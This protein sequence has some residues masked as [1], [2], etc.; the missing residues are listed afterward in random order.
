MDTS[1]TIAVFAK[2]LRNMDRW[3][4]TAVEHAK[5]KGFDPEVYA[6]ARLAPDQYDLIR[7]VQAACDQAKYA[8]AYLSQQPP[9]SHPD[10]ERTIEELRARIQTALRYV[11]T[12]EP[13]S[14]KTPADIRISPA[15]MQ[16]KWVPGD[17]YL[18]EITIP[19]FYFHVCHVYAI[20]RHNGVEL[21]KMDFIGGLEMR[22]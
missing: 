3:I 4:E 7:Q 1:A 10:T 13:A 21:G 5:K 6:V 15:W 17:V 14:D 8:A 9:P 11:E 12:F 16:G 18:N 20:L 22:D 19:N 2:M